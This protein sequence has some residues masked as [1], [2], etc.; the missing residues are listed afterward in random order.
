MNKA[1]RPQA[2]HYSQEEAQQEAAR[3]IQCRCTECLDGCAFLRHYK[4]Y[5]KLYAREVFNNSTIV[6]GIHGANSMINACSLCGQCKVICPN[7]FDMGEICRVAREDM[8]NQ[9]QKCRH[10]P[11]ILL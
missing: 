4:R 10:L 8:V 7:G 2:I 9:G 6:M 3:C 1:I 11:M 5:P